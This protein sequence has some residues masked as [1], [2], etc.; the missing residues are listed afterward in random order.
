MWCVMQGVCEK[1]ATI[2][3]I[4]SRLRENWVTFCFCTCV[5]LR[6]LK[7]YDCIDNDELVIRFLNCSLVGSDCLTCVGDFVVWS[8]RINIGMAK[9]GLRSD[10]DHLGSKSNRNQFRNW[11]R[12]I[13]A[14]G[15]MDLEIK[16][17][18]LIIFFL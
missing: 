16:T 6:V 17:D 4:K 18:Y 3:F 11:T 13:H 9:N 1:K 8:C 10:L 2:V 7:H 15:D 14:K 5:T 12:K